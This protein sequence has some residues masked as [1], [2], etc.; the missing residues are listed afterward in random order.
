MSAKDGTKIKP[1]L[2][3]LATAAL[4]QMLPAALPNLVKRVV[5]ELGKPDRL[6]FTTDEAVALTAWMA[7]NM[8]FK[9]FHTGVR[10]DLLRAKMR[11][12]MIPDAL[13]ACILMHRL[14]RD[15]HDNLD[16]ILGDIEFTVEVLLA[17]EFV[18]GDWQDPHDPAKQSVAAT[19]EEVLAK[20][21][22]MR[23]HAQFLERLANGKTLEDEAKAL[24]ATARGHVI[25]GPHEKVLSNLDEAVEKLG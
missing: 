7:K 18:L 13:P 11:P 17:S 14:G 19:R 4:E 6:K 10:G 1:G 9:I 23:D 25:T 2:L 3:D 22:A 20:A 21:D 16:E 24:L 15:Y 5:D 8:E 12:V